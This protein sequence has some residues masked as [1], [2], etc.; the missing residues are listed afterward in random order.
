MNTYNL[1]TERLLIKP[2][3]QAN[4]H[5][6]HNLHSLPEVNQFNTLGIP[7]NINVTKA[8]LDK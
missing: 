2:I 3:T 1:S 7:E 8:I 5:Y 4:L 6:V